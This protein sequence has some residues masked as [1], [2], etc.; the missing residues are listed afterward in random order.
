MQGNCGSLKRIN[1]TY[2]DG[3]NNMSEQQV[4]AEPILF[5]NNRT[6]T[7]SSH[8]VIV[9][10]LNRNVGGVP[11]TKEMFEASLPEWDGIPLVFAQ[12]HPDMELYDRDPEAALNAVAG[13]HVGTFTTPYIKDAG[14]PRMWGKFNFTDPQ[15][16]QLS[17]EGKLSLST[18]FWAM[19][20]Q[21]GEYVSTRPQNILVFEETATDLPRDLGTGILNKTPIHPNQ[22]DLERTMTDESTD[23]GL[24]A[25]ELVAVQNKLKTAEEKLTAEESKNKVLS[26][27]IAK[28][29]EQ[30]ETLTK[31]VATFKQAEQDA[32][33][34]ALANKL[35]KGLVHDEAA[36]KAARTEWEADPQTF[37]L[38][39]VDAMSKAPEGTGEEG[40]QFMQS[41]A[42]KPD[43]A[44]EFM[45]TVE[46]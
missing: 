17:D 12:K 36:T 21:S 10:T 28:K 9:Q 6:P 41:G 14:H 5:S 20:N 32:K 16:K 30:I 29:D 7:N 25:T 43:E 39:V 23:T 40:Q 22:N 11:L 26:G 45:I 8:D 27:E 4:F 42:S 3:I 46:E 33:W 34:T 44:D 37:M 2:L 19:K 31:E 18:A 35:P 24:V 1:N 13:R 38:K 15:M